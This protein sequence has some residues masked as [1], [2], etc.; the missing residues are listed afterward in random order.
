MKLILMKRKIEKGKYYFL[1][2]NVFGC[3]VGYGGKIVQ[4]DNNEF[5]LRTDEYCCL[6]FKLKDIIYFKEKE[7]FKKDL[8]IVVRKKVGKEG[9][10]EFGKPKF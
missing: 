4:I 3:H 1:K 6:R 8:R 5:G 7:E 10:K 9:L 2:I